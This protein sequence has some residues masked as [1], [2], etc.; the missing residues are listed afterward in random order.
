[1]ICS[2]PAAEQRYES[3]LWSEAG[4][5]KL[6]QILLIISVLLL[7]AGSNIGCIVVKDSPAPGCVQYL[8]QDQEAL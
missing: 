1:M 4:L 7:L 5:F 8:Y 3:K 6:G 2:V